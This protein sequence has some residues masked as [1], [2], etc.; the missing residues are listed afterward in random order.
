MTTHHNKIF[1]PI[2][3][4]A[5]RLTRKLEISVFA[6]NWSNYVKALRKYRSIGRRRGKTFGNKPKK[7]ICRACGY[8]N[9]PSIGHC[10]MC[11]IPRAIATGRH[12]IKESLYISREQAVYILIS[13]LA[14]YYHVM[15]LKVSMTGLEKTNSN[16]IYL[17]ISRWYSC[18]YVCMLSIVIIP[19]IV[20]F[21]CP[22]LLTIVAPGISSC[23]TVCRAW[24]ATC[25]RPRA[26]YK[27]NLFD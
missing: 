13:G 22:C 24:C 23:S 14:H 19:N 16:T 11:K 12:C 17:E 26:K 1:H 18:K 4:R 2:P 9:R 3:A 10:I 21:T 7:I 6:Q 8:H 5:G 15:Y 20:S 27:N 25:P